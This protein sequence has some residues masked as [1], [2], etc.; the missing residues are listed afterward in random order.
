MTNE[1]E[2]IIIKYHYSHT[3]NY[4]SYQVD[5]I[6]GGIT[7]QG[8]IYMEIFT[9]RNPVPEVIEHEIT[10]EGLGT[11][12]KRHPEKEPGKVIRQIECGLV[13]DRGTGEAIR[14]W[15]KEKLNSL[16]QLDKLKREQPK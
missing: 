12:I 7:P 4:R 10:R 9:E 3:Q 1:K 16:A 2:T 8:K 11:E 15:L 6:F 13:I 14:E 5:G